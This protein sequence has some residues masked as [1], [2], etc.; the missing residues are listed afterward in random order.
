MQECWNELGNVHESFSISCE[1]L[2]LIPLNRLVLEKQVISTSQCFCYGS[3]YILP[4][5]LNWG[6]KGETRI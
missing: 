5:W 6:S 3:G 1:C 4:L 2:S